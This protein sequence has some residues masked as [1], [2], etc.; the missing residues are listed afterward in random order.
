M[1]G[2]KQILTRLPFQVFVLYVVINYFLQK[3][4]DLELYHAVV[5]ESR[6]GVVSF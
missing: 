5:V 3:K 2:L 6:V 4:I 1:H